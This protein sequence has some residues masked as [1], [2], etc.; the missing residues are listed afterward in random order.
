[1]KRIIWPLLVIGFPFFVVNLAWS[2]WNYSRPR[3]QNVPGA[4]FRVLEVQTN[5]AIGTEI[6]ERSTERPLWIK[7]DLD[8]DGKPDVISYFFEGTNVFNLHLNS[9]HGQK[10]GYDVIFY[11]PG[12]SQTWWWDHGSGSF[13]ERI[14]YDT[15][16]DLSEHEVWYAGDWQTV[17]RRD[18]KNG[19]VTGDAWHHLVLGS[20]GVWSVEESSSASGPDASPDRSQ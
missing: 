13:N 3:A 4:E 20:N 1:M 16:G 2:V 18:D 11:G 19:I 8:G 15:N 9:K 10:L 17:E 14:R 7:W 6:V 12:R 5:K